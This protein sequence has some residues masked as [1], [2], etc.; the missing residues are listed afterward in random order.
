MKNNFSEI[1]CG[2]RP[3]DGKIVV[4][5]SVLVGIYVILL[6]MIYKESYSFMLRWWNSDDYNYCYTIP[7]MVAYL[8][9]E[10]RAALRAQPSGTSWWGVVPLAL[11][12]MFCLVGEL[13]GEYYTLYFSSWLMVSGL[14]LLHL[15]WPRLRTIAFPLLFSIAMFPFPNA[16]NNP[17]SLKLKLVSSAAGV[18]ILQLLGFAAF[19]EGH[20]IDLGS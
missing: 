10:Q 11:G 3:I 18:K 9:W 1:A 15:G 13:G 6:I 2:M 19:R 5:R 12:A 4:L 14:L 20:V 8:V 7:P 17:L 16:I